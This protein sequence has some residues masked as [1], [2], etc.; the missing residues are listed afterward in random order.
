MILNIFICHLIINDVMNI[1]LARKPLT[2]EICG[3]SDRNR[4]R[5]P[6]QWQPNKNEKKKQKIGVGKS[7]FV[8]LFLFHFIFYVC[9]C[10]FC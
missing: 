8:S 7:Q 6:R 2:N 9:V 1:N 3:N 5:G 10:V 4:E